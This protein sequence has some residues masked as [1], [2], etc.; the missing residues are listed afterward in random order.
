MNL[1][2]LR[3]LTTSS[4]MNDCATD[5]SSREVNPRLHQSRLT[6]TLLERILSY[7]SSLCLFIFINVGNYCTVS[8]NNGFTWRIHIRFAATELKSVR[9]LIDLTVTALRFR[10][11]PFYQTVN[12]CMKW[13]WVFTNDY[14]SYSSK[15]CCAIMVTMLN[16]SRSLDGLWISVKAVVFRWICSYSQ[17]TVYLQCIKWQVICYLT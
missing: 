9:L 15:A 4:P 1:Q 3:C 11:K 13:Y 16:F 10:R 5:Y 14:L 17:A 2:G 8:A 7:V 6:S 12:Q